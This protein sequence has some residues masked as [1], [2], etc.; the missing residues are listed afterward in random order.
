MAKQPG[1]SFV[2]LY[3]VSTVS[4]P[5][6]GGP[7]GVVVLE[8]TDAADEDT[9]GTDD[10]DELLP[11]ADEDAAGAELTEAVDEDDETERGAEDEDDDDETDTGTDDDDDDETGVMT[12]DDGAAEDEGA[13]GEEE[14]E[15]GDGEAEEDELDELGRTGV[16]EELETGTPTYAKAGSVYSPAS[17]LVPCSVK[18]IVCWFCDKAICG[19][20]SSVDVWFR[21]TVICMGTPELSG[22][23]AAITCGVCV[24]CTSGDSLPTSTMYSV[25]SLAFIWREKGKFKNGLLYSRV[26]VDVLGMATARPD[27]DIEYTLATSELSVGVVK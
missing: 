7:P 12:E 8:L 1:A 9:A 18:Y 6:A 13:T 24:G 2:R 27:A 17:V 25:L 22:P 23:N 10:A 15:E 16:A 3:V 14:D 11:T 26:G 19:E 21:R 5:V 4:A 20:M